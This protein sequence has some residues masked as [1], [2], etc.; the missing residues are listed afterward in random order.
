ME[1]QHD[2]AKLALIRQLANA[3]ARR[4]EFDELIPFVLA[5]CRELLRASG[6]SLLLFD[7]EHNEL[8]FLDVSEGDAEA[9]Q[10]ISSEQRR[11]AVLLHLG[12]RVIVIRRP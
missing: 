5:R 9:A 11:R 4:L 1:V 10:S 7:P 6:V 12:H 8:Y 2:S 3:F